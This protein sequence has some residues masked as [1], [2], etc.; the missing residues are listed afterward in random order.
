MLLGG[1]RRQFVKDSL[2]LYT[3]NSKRYWSSEK[4][5]NLILWLFW[6]YISVIIGS[7]VDGGLV[8]TYDEIRVD[9]AFEITCD[10]LRPPHSAYYHH[11]GQVR[12]V[13][14]YCSIAYIVRFPPF[15]SSIMFPIGEICSGLT[16]RARSH[17]MMW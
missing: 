3:L 10:G 8:G 16:T 15:L 1:S 9:F 13:C 4:G 2:G 11:L 17:P 5:Y 6:N 7:L 14:D 12:S